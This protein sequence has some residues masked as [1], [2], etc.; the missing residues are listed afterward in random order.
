M[1]HDT[2]NLS[3]TC[4]VRSIAYEDTSSVSTDPPCRV[5]LRPLQARGLVREIANLLNTTNTCTM[6]TKDMSRVRNTKYQ[7]PTTVFIS[8]IPAS[9]VPYTELM[10]LDRPGGSYALY[11][12]C[13]FGVFYAAI[14]IPVQPPPA[15]IADRT[16]TL[17]LCL[18][19]RAWSSLHMERCCRS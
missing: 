2:V 17:L 16:I 10:R 7:P 15:F 18:Y 14:T 3:G 1:K 9:W 19:P 12:P 13:L 6:A 8:Y 4:S 11:I 5:S